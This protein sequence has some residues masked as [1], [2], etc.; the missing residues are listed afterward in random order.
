MNCIIYNLRKTL[1]WRAKTNILRDWH[2]IGFEPFSSRTCRL[3][4]LVVAIFANGDF[5]RWAL[6]SVQRCVRC[7]SMHTRQIPGVHPYTK[8]VLSALLNLLDRRSSY[9]GCFG[10]LF[11][12]ICWTFIS[13]YVVTIVAHLSTC[14]QKKINC[15]WFY[16]HM[17]DLVR[18]KVR[19]VERDLLEAPAVAYMWNCNWRWMK[20]AGVWIGSPIRPLLNRGSRK[21]LK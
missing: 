3:N 11:P 7:L 12:L 15:R 8:M 13:R 17:G 10:F 18:L 2:L 14:P 6:Y 9:F 20:I 16:Y 4:L 19:W 21:L 1:Y 5:F